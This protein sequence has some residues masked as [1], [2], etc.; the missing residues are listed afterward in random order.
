MAHKHYISRGFSCWETCTSTCQRKAKQV[1][2]KCMG[3]GHTLPL[4]VIQKWGTLSLSGI[5]KWG[6]LSYY[7][8][9]TEMGHTPTV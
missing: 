7:E 9:H 3:M 1:E 6:T 5:Q 2:E 8:W 4:S